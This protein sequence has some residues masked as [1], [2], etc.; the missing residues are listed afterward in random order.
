[1]NNLVKHQSD[2]VKIAMIIAIGAIIVTILVLMYATGVLQQGGWVFLLFG[3][4][5][6]YN[7]W[8]RMN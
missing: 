4:L 5:I 7:L 2:G 3:V 6:S 1:M 8:Q